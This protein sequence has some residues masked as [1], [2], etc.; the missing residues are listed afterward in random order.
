MAQSHHEFVVQLNEYVTHTVCRNSK[1]DQHISMYFWRVQLL[2]MA[3]FHHEGI[4]DL[5]LWI[6]FFGLTG[7]DCNFSNTCIYII[8][9]IEYMYNVVL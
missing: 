9:I 4:L 8:I 7:I 3:Q 5:G 6:L 2:Q 1:D